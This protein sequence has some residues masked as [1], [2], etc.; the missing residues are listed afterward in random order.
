MNDN[1]PG[2]PL[3]WPD[4][5]R[6]TKHPASSRFEGSLGRIQKELLDEIGRLGGILPVI[7]ANIPLRKDGLHYASYK[8]PE[9]KGVAVY[10]QL[11]GKSMAMACDKW[12]RIEDNMK[13]IMKTIEAMRGMERW[14]VSE[15][16]DRVFQGFKALPAPKRWWDILGVPSDA[17]EEE[18]KQA[19]RDLARKHHPDMGGD[20]AQ[21]AE[22]N[23]ANKEAMEQFR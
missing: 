13:A 8:N 4:G 9:D 10:F 16:T 7:S 20:G 22:I 23:V 1:I 5:V 19:Y 3:Q 12:D 21:L 17:T 2:Y 15:V 6:R 18:I 11:N 14:G